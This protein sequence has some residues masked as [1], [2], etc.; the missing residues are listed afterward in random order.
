MLATSHASVKTLMA[1]HGPVHRGCQFTLTDTRTCVTSAH[2][3]CAWAWVTGWSRACGSGP[4]LS[5]RACPTSSS[6]HPRLAGLPVRRLLSHGFLSLQASVTLCAGW[7]REVLHPG[8]RAEA[9][10]LPEQGTQSQACDRGLPCGQGPGNE[11]W[12]A[13]AAYS[14]SGG[15]A[16]EQGVSIH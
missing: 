1:L 12:P 11:L 2:R 7:G 8:Q 5:G 13:F 14:C 9:W 6:F 16:W 4:L 15:T 10:M 3:A